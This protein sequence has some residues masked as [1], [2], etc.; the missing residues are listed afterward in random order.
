MRI[1]I[2]DCVGI[3]QTQTAE[4]IFGILFRLIAGHDAVLYR[5]FAILV[6]QFMS[7]IEGRRCRLRYIGDAVAAQFTALFIG[8]PAQFQP[9]E[10][11][12]PTAQSTAIPGIAHGGQSNR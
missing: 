11:D 1:A 10:P 3:G 2:A 8:C 9:V 7:G 4:Q 6:D 12:F 5:S